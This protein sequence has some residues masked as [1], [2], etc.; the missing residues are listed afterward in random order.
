[1][2]N[3]DRL[4]YLKKAFDVHKITGIFENSTH[5]IEY[6]YNKKLAEKLW[7]IK[8][9]I[10]YKYR[11]CNENNINALRKKTIWFSSPDSWNDPVDVTVSFGDN[12]VFKSSNDY[13]NTFIKKTTLKMCVKN[14]FDIIGRGK[15]PI[16]MVQNI[17]KNII[18]THEINYETVSNCFKPYLSTND[19]NKFSKFVCDLYTRL[20]NSKYNNY[21][22]LSINA[23]KNLNKIKRKLRI[24]SFSETY[25]NQ[26]QW[27]MYADSGKGFCIGYDIRY[28][29]LENLEW[30]LFPIYYGNKKIINIEKYLN[31]AFEYE[32]SHTKPYNYYNRF[33]KI[34]YTSFF[35]KDTTWQQEE[36]WRAV[37]CYKKKNIVDFD[38]AKAI[39]LGENISYKWKKELIKIAKLQN[40]KIY[41][42]QLDCTKSNWNYVEI[43]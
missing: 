41:Q 29:N 32:L 40:L 2:K 16:K 8:P 24:C 30:R 34:I 23:I 14:F 33:T 39:Y 38:F 9:T 37:L 36:E 1:M 27:A 20:S 7:N 12:Y 18:E 22:L 10:I 15:Y 19:C 3:K 4:I 17:L 35:T 25:N 13:L 21:F 28:A 6:S 43:I 31:D 26:H 5:P 11:Y 42:R